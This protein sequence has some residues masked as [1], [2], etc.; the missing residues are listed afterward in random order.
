[1]TRGNPTERD[2]PDDARD[3]VGDIVDIH[4]SYAGTLPSSSAAKGRVSYKERIRA[5]FS[6][7]LWSLA[8]QEDQLWPEVTAAMVGKPRGSRIIPPDTSAGPVVGV[9]FG[10][11]LFS[12]LVSEKRKLT[13]HLDITLLHRRAP[14]TILQ[15]GD[16]DNRLKTL[17]DALRVPH[18]LNE[19]DLSRQEAMDRWTLCLLEDDALVTRLT[20]KTGRLLAGLP[21][22][23][24]D[25]DH[26]VQ[27]QV[28]ASLKGRHE[29]TDWMGQPE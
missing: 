5:E 28:V 27:L 17:L 9:K 11:R 29:L 24:G 12:P 3:I 26:D 16:L 25:P 6:L 4:L 15:G 13:C 20:I 2:W 18:D 10:P 21:L 1:M 14:G 19:V 22:E 7:Q 23:Q 8:M